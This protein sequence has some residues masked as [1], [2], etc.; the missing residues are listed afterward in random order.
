[1]ILTRGARL[2]AYEVIAAI[3]AGGMGE[4]YRARDP[5]LRR[6]TA[7][8]VL[9]AEFAQDAERLERFQREA[10]AIAALNHPNVVTIYSVEE[11]DGIHFLTMELIEGKTLADLIPPRGMPLATLLR[12][13]VPLTDAVSAAHHRGIVHRDLKPANVMMTSDGRVKVL[14]FGLAKLKQKVTDAGG[15][16][17]T[18]TDPA[19]GPQNVTGTPAYMSPE[20]AEGRDVDTRSDVFSLGV[21]LYEMATG[22]RPFQ[23]TSA[24]SVISS[25]IKDTPTPIA[26]I[27]VDLPADFDRIVRRC[28]AKDPARRYQSALEVRNELEDLQQVLSDPAATGSESER[29]RRRNTR[30]MIALGLGVIIVGA[31]VYAIAEWRSHRAPRVTP[32]RA[33][34]TRLT[35]QP[36][37]EFFPSISPDGKWIV[38]SGESSGNRD[39]YLQSVSGETAI[40]LTHDCAEDDEQPAFSPDGEYIAFR[41]GRDGGGIFIMGR[42]GEA[43]RRVTRAGFNPAWS[44]DGTELAYTRVRT[45][46]RPQNAEERSELLVVGVNGG[47]PRV[48]HKGDSML[49]TWS[50]GGGRIAF[51]GRFVQ[52][53][54]RAGVANIFTLRV[55]GGQPEP[56]TRGN[57]IDW[58]P[59]WAA[60]GRQIYF[61][62]NRGG[63]P[64]IW[65]IGIDEASGRP[66][67]DP[68][69]LTSPSSF[70]AH[71]S[72][73][74]DGRRL[75]FSSI[76]EA[77]NIQTLRFDPAA[78]EIVGDVAPITTGSR[79]WS[80]PDP[81]P[82]GQWV[83]F[84]SQV[85][86]EGDLY[87]A[88]TDGSGTMRQLTSD[89]AI[90][91]VPRWSPDGNWIAMFSDRSG[92]LEVWKVR[93]DGSELQQV[94]GDGGGV[95]AWSPN[96]A[97]LAIT[98]GT[99]TR[100]QWMNLIIDSSRHER[101]QT[102][103]L[104]A[105][106]TAPHPQFVPNSW[107]PNGRL[108]VGQNGYSVLGLSTY[109][110]ETRTYDRLIE[111]GEW[112]VWL[113]DGRRILFVSR[114]REFHVMDVRSKAT[115]RVFSIP[116]GTLGPPRMTRD[117]RAIYFS[118]R[119]T[120]SDVWLA[121]LQ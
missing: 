75:A 21:M 90:D 83:V 27:R 108:L 31:G 76:L 29:E 63:S 34:F 107:S 86:P 38:Y 116:R 16:T 37:A 14:D 112:P 41:S 87:I 9:T 101:D 114:G 23:G 35:S 5:R 68:E 54:I 20:Q 58:N 56:L 81:S 94:T 64:N 17:V 62:S 92:V 105:P 39:V 26:Q 40:N 71:L 111:F 12:I 118:R 72:L 57:F 19:T 84:Y 121:T 45:E 109:S 119:V 13:A 25:I 69:P 1:V 97:Q 95:V 88:R 102:P 55:A 98:R 32:L 70:A 6:D 36:G 120:E 2:G 15:A 22:R 49:P 80:S 60:D 4:V 53:Q 113:P 66:T 117:G 44:R 7:V 48:L 59:V 51:S 47:E 89:P 11:A 50:P 96:G 99:A 52:G 85:Q 91:R 18:V 24:I 43:V 42:T 104:L 10:Q 67:G 8:K 65:R 106:P 61:V 74:S 78:G 115:R 28:L 93:A 73:S 46:I 103:V 3:G 33:T 82:D 77:Q 79:Y 30:M 110:F 100:H